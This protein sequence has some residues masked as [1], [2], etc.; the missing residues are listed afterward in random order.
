MD[1]VFQHKT[2]WAAAPKHDPW[3]HTEVVFFLAAGVSLPESIKQ[4]LITQGLGFISIEE[5][6]S[7]R[8]LSVT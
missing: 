2:L 8:N 3:H 6:L 5:Y 7:S 1:G 4:Q